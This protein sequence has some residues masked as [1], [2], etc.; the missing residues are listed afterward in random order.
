MITTGRRN[1]SWGVKEFTWIDLPDPA[2]PG[3]WSKQYEAKINQAREEQAR[4]EQIKSGVNAALAHA[5]RNRYTL[6]IYQQNNQ[7]QN[8]PTR[9]LLALHAYDTA[10]DTAGLAAARQAVQAVLDSFIPMRRELETVYGKTR[11]MVQPE[12]FIAD[13]NHHNHLAAKT[14]SSDWLYYYELPMNRK[15]QNWL[16][17]H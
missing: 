17:T 4:Y 15:V 14:N 6:Q 13:H 3:A 5:R 12:G 8:Y 16:R 10:T 9:L 1:P 2:N 11:F 7:L